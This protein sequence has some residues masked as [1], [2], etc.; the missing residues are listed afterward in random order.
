[1][2]QAGQNAALDTE[3]FEDIFG[4]HTPPNDLDSYKTLECFVIAYAQIDLTHTA[5]SQFPEQTVGARLL[6]VQL[7]RGTFI[8]GRCH[9]YQSL[10]KIRT[11]GVFQKRL[12][13]FRRGQ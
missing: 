7:I 13:F 8:H 5:A 12:R 9:L 10:L 4:I 11:L 3:A 1:M 2:V 6:Q